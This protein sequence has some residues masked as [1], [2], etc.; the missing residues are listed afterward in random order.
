MHELCIF[1][2]KLH[3]NSK[4]RSV[5]VE[6][7]KTRH[8]TEGRSIGAAGAKIVCVFSRFGF[9]TLSTFSAP[10][11]LTRL[12]W[13]FFQVVMVRKDTTGT[14][15][16]RFLRLGWNASKVA[17]DSFHEVAKM[18]FL[19]SFYTESN[20]R[21]EHKPL[22]ITQSNFLKPHLAFPHDVAGRYV[23]VSEVHSTHLCIVRMNCLR[24]LVALLV[25]TTKSSF[26][27]NF[28]RIICGRKKI[29]VF[30]VRKFYAQKLVFSH[31]STLKVAKGL[32]SKLLWHSS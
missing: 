22:K 18:H 12:C 24:L 14:P 9:S 7:P 15:V 20:K 26:A 28:S 3:N 11:R 29:H 2:S 27:L 5:D 25:T 21:V 6:I 8:Y 19:V 32:L 4:N 16:T 23:L 31:V 10:P 13:Y 30:L 17:N 1:C